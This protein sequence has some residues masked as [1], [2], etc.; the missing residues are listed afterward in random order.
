MQSPASERV[1]AA[2]GTGTQYKYRAFISYSRADR[3]IAIPL[4]RALER[5]TVPK[6]LQIAS[7]GQFRG[8]RPLSPVFRDED[9]LIPGGD[10][11]NRIREGLRNSEFLIILCSP[12]AAQSQWVEK[13]ILDF[14]SLGGE[15]RMLAVV[16]DGEPGANK[17][18][19]SNLREALPLALRRRVIDGQI[20]EE[21]SEPLWID[22]RKQGRGDRLNFLRLAGALLQLDSLDDLIRRDQR[23]ERTRRRVA[24]VVAASIVALSLGLGVAGVFAYLQASEA[25]RLGTLA[26]IRESMILSESARQA[27]ERGDYE[28]AHSI[29]LRAMPEAAERPLILEAAKELVLSQSSLLQTSRVILPVTGREIALSPDGRR[30]VVKT[31]GMDSSTTLWDTLSG[32]MIRAI[33]LHD[34]DSSPTIFSADSQRVL[35]G[36]D[37]LDANSGK[38]IGPKV[39]PDSG[40][41]PVAAAFSSDSKSLAIAYREPNIRNLG[42]PDVFGTFSVF[43]AR[44]GTQILGP[45]NSGLE[46]DT[47]ALSANGNILILAG[48]AGKRPSV[49]IWN[50]GGA[51]KT[52]STIE[53]G[54]EIVVFSPDNRVSRAALVDQASILRI[55]DTDTGALVGKPIHLSQYSAAMTPQFATDGV[56]LVIAAKP[57]QSGGPVQIQLVDAMTGALV[58]ERLAESNEF[59]GCRRASG[60]GASFLLSDSMF[61]LQAMDAVRSGS[62]DPLSGGDGCWLSHDGRTAM[63]SNLTTVRLHRQER[64]AFEHKDLTFDGPIDAADLSDNGAIAAVSIRLRGTILLNSHISHVTATFPKSTVFPE[65]AISPRGDFAYSVSNGKVGKIWHLGTG[66]EAGKFFHSDQPIDQLKYTADGR[67]LFAKFGDR[68]VAAWNLST[69][70]RSP[71]VVS[72][73]AIQ[74][75]FPSGDGNWVVLQRGSDIDRC[76]IWHCSAVQTSTLPGNFT[77]LGVSNDGRT[78]V[79]ANADS[80]HLWQDGAKA[81]WPIAEIPRSLAVSPDGH[82]VAV[83]TKDGGLEVWDLAT[84]RKVPWSTEQIER[85]WDVA[86]SSDST[87]L[88]V[89]Q[90]GGRLLILG[91]ETGAVFGQVED[92]RAVVDE[93]SF[94]ADGSMLLSSLG[95]LD[96]YT[97]AK[98][99]STLYLE[100]E[101]K[102]GL[103]ARSAITTNGSTYKLWALNTGLVAYNDRAAI[104]RLV[105]ADLGVASGQQRFVSP[106]TTPTESPAPTCFEA[107][108]RI[109]DPKNPALGLLAGADFADD[110]LEPLREGEIDEIRDTCA[111]DAAEL[112][113]D[114]RYDFIQGVLATSEDDSHLDS[115]AEKGFGLAHFAKA[116]KLI[117]RSKGLEAHAELVAADR[118]D[119]AAAKTVL[120]EL[121]WYGRLVKQNKTNAVRYWNAASALGSTGAHLRLA[122]LL[123]RNEIAMPSQ[124]DNAASALLHWRAVANSRHGRFET[125]RAVSLARMLVRQQRWS[126][127]RRLGRSLEPTNRAWFERLVAQ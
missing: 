65:G 7:A 42:D 17:R 19:A 91:T 82:Q 107:A 33:E 127:L 68:T 94:S 102:L 79:L 28:S 45:L 78:L 112:G 36:A 27:R 14:I 35:N 97:G 29:A 1:R 24:Q 32:A 121:V 25:A 98:L 22:W 116:L 20:T 21:P 18:E 74:T 72:R 122:Q 11:P 69:G 59:G 123:D 62:I 4:Q 41:S 44:T 3:Q 6:A 101:T 2:T 111:K 67:S 92:N 95:L 96:G 26:L 100:D 55:I 119:I 50:V 58:N 124:D 117:A 73:G 93:V 16:V 56:H 103:T 38:R 49:Q 81:T 83:I 15:G 110:L 125:F 39:F 66:A 75:Y 47:I 115:A 109:L 86:F 70:R 105:D 88:A 87:R 51:R 113:S 34:Y 48:N 63:E 53:V 90:E 52:S 118:G 120:A 8:R 85:A 108:A 61:R 77:L 64:F 84:L 104:G 40:V 57:Q 46:L 114:P 13:E 71:P 43:D 60:A 9:E 30:I 54:A 126:T 31:R 5:F 10:L 37:L 23:A 12:S 99:L 80:R 76:A 89:T 106:S